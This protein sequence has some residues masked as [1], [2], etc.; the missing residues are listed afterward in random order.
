MVTNPNPCKRLSLLDDIPERPSAKAEVH[1][2]KIKQF[3]TPTG[4]RMWDQRVPS[5]GRWRSGRDSNPV[6]GK[7][8]Q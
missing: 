2:L 3:L 8:N 5:G 1:S 6:K 7:K 4:F